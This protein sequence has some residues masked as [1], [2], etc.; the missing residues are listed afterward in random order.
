MLDD[1][2]EGE[3]EKSKGGKDRRRRNMEVER[4]EGRSKRDGKKIAKGG[5]G[6]T[7]DNLPEG[8]IVRKSIGLDWMLPPTQKTERNPALDL[9]E[10]LEES[11]PEEVREF[12][13]GVSI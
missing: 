3:K 6:E 1:S 12:R 11:T 10:K 8:D 7:V 13:F 2:S 9:E 5:D 4:K